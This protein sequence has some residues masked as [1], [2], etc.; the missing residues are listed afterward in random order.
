MNATLQPT[1][2]LRPPRPRRAFT[3]VEVLVVVAIIGILASMVL[4]ALYVAME[5]ARRTRTRTLVDKLHNQIMLRWEEFETRR[6][7]LA[8]NP[9]ATPD[10]IALDQLIFLNEIMR[11]E[12]PDSYLDLNLQYYDPFNAG[13]Q[14]LLEP[15]SFEYAGLG[16]SRRPDPNEMTAPPVTEYLPSVTRAY[17]ERVIANAKRLKQVNPTLYPTEIAALDGMIRENQSA[18]MLYLIVN[19]SYGDEDSSGVHFGDR[20]VADTDEDGMPEFVDAWGHPIEWIRWPAGYANINTITGGTNPGWGFVTDLISGD[21]ASDPD[22]FDPRR[23]RIVNNVAP[24]A[25]PIPPSMPPTPLYSYRLV[26]LIMSPGPDGEYGIVFRREVPLAWPVADKARLRQ[27]YSDPYYFWEEQSTG[28]IR[29][30][31]Q[32]ARVDRL[33]GKFDELPQPDDG[34]DIG[35][36]VHH[37]NITN[38]LR[39]EE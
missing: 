1:S 26:P 16:V 24:T 11:M 14:S 9:A 22:P 36:W 6:V 20:D 31:G 28:F 12:L 10:Q 17:Q 23:V 8:V 37:D 29:R 39:E 3:L 21:A 30:R 13:W 38:H 4:G 25:D 27:Q 32:P 19:T 35:E 15:F 2:D 5:S 33:D 18:E 7:P 34:D